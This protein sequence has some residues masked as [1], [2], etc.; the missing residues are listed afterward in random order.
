[1][2]QS[3]E[4]FN[5]S[6]VSCTVNKRTAVIRDDTALLV[7]LLYY[8]DVHSRGESANFSLGGR[9]GDTLGMLRYKSLW[10]KVT[11]SVTSTFSVYSFSGSEVSKPGLTQFLISRLRCVDTNHLVADWIHEQRI[12]HPLQNFCRKSDCRSKRCTY[13]K[14]GLKCSLA[15]G[16]CKGISLF[17]SPSPSFLLTGT[18]S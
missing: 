2:S 5:R 18:I 17:N 6:V 12:F 7:L 16:E 4:R 10:E 8:A 3:S 15:C 14:H 9:A 13:R 1:M 11:P